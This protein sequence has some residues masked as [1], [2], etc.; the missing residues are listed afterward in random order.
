[1]ASSVIPSLLALLAAPDS[2]DKVVLAALRTLNSVADASAL[3]HLGT[4]G[5]GKGLIHSLYTEDGLTGILQLLSQDSSSSVVQDQIALAA[6]LIGK[7]CHD[8]RQRNLLV[9]RGVLEAL[10]S[11]L[12]TFIV[13]T[14]YAFGTARPQRDSP[15]SPSILP[16]TSR[17]RLAPILAA[18]GR[19]VDISKSR[20]QSFLSTPALT[21][22]L[23]RLEANIAGIAGKK[24]VPWHHSATFGSARPSALGKLDDLLPQVPNLPNRAPLPESSYHPPLGVIGTSTRQP[25]STRTLNNAQDTTYCQASIFAPEPENPLIAWLIYIARAENGVARSM[26]AWIISLFYR[27]GLIDKQREP[28]LAML[29]VPLL[30]RTLDRDARD[31]TDDDSAYKTHPSRSAQWKYQEQAPEILAV[32]TLDSPDLQRA[33]VD[34]GVIKKLAQLLKE[35]YDPLPT[36]TSISQWNAEPQ[37]DVGSDGCDETSSVVDSNVSPVA[38][39]LVRVREAALKALGAIASTRDDYRKAIIE[40]GA[41]PFLIESLK[42]ERGVPTAGDH[43]KVAAHAARNSK[44]VILAACGAARSLS[45][46][47]STLR[48]SLMDA[49]LA[50]PL[51]ALLK[52]DDVKVQIAATAVIT[53]LVLEFSPMREVRP[54][55]EELRIQEKN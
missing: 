30:V 18:I 7:T 45:R 36:D 53:N 31:T 47:V 33:A 27:S 15:E 51:F 29:L 20:A 48:T 22:V 46:S 26:A 2:C 16:A 43:S 37:V 3:K 12:S 42:S 1:M 9:R 38:Y 40:N 41:I 6:A 4:N 5:H 23:L 8:D 19:V 54:G 11:R 55:T 52:H 10:A 49:G 32:L 25:F 44:G 39:Q 28:S 35:S 50:A 34:A 13:A 14:D 17:S 21:V 24:A